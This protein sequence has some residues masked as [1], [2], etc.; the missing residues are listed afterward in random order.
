MK[1]LDFTSKAIDWFGSY[2]KKQNIVVSL[3]K[4][5]LETGILSCGVS[6]GSILG[7]ILFLLHV[8][9]MKKTL[10]T[11]RFTQIHVYSTATKVSTSLK[12]I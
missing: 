4:T 2:L 8:N 1:Y 6:Q 10:K 11:F 12:K 7:P 3:E 5:L 9:D